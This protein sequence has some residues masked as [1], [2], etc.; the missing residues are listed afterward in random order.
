MNAETWIQ[1]AERLQQ[2]LGH[3]EMRGEN[4]KTKDKTAAESERIK[5]A[6][7][8]RREFSHG[9]DASTESVLSSRGAP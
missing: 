3:A 8:L 6:L 5:I 4:E 7:W 2:S 1:K 9:L